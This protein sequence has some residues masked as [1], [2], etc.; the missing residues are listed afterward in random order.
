MNHMETTF[1]Q[2]VQNKEVAKHKTQNTLNLL[3]R[4]GM[5]VIKAILF[6]SKNTEIFHYLFPTFA[7]KQTKRLSLSHSRKSSVTE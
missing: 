5:A 1:T 2:E 6:P 7:T 4:H 3:Q